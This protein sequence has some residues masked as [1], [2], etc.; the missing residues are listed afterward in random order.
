MAISKKVISPAAK[1]KELVE[2]HDTE[3]A[4]KIVDG[5]LTEVQEIGWDQKRI[6]YYLD[7]KNCIKI[8]AEFKANK[9]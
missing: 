2:R 4:D 5:L 8:I 6:D 7:V 1:A 9:A 3:I